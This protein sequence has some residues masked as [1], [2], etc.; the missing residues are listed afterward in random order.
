MAIQIVDYST[1]EYEK[2]V[3]LRYQILRKPLHLE[4]KEG[5]L[6]EDKNCIWI[7]CFE[8]GKAIGCCGLKKIDA[9]TVQLRQMAVNSG[10]QG[11]GIGRAIVNFAENIAT[12]FGFKKMVMHARKSAQGFYEKLGY[13]AYGD[14]FTEV[15]IPHMMMRKSLS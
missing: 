2:L 5:D 3:R 9:T 1:P 12:D 8:S 11:K 7:G 14:E 10:I 13:L 4:F 6:E 15:T